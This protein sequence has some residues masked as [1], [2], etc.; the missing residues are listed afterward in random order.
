MDYNS[1]IEET[2][3]STLVINVLRGRDAA[4]LYFSDLSQVRGS[5]S[6]GASTQATIPFG[7]PGMGSRTSIQAGAFSANTNPTF[8]IAPTNTK[9]FYQGLLN[10]IS[11]SLFAYFIERSRTTSTEWVFHLLVASI[12]EYDKITGNSQILPARGKNS[13]DFLAKANLWTENE[14]PKVVA[15][16]AGPKPFGPPIRADAKALIDANNA[17]LGVKDVGHG[18][19]QLTAKSG[20]SQLCFYE[21]GNDGYVPVSVV[22][23]SVTKGP[24]GEDVPSLG[25]PEPD[26]SG[27]ANPCNPST[28]HSP[29]KKYFLRLRSVEQIFNYLGTLVDPDDNSRLRPPGDPHA[30]CPRIPFF[31]YTVPVAGSRFSVAYRGTTYYVASASYL[32]PCSNGVNDSTLQILAILND[33]LNLNRDANE[34][35]TTKAV[36][37]VGGG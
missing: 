2:S 8:D 11:G 27:L 36:Q 29:R 5:V 1:T 25:G 18:L 16:S 30:G 23:N 32:N 34:I 33:L 6:M 14:P 12:E 35:P 20:G 24:T 22:Q 28:G 19:V 17:G 10:P 31:L 7:Q 21:G 15:L 13:S 3:N 9:Q 26:R 37:A 4:P